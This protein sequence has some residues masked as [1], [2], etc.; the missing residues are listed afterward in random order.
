M[1]RKEPTAEAELAEDATPP[2]AMPKEEMQARGF[3]AARQARSEALTEDYVELI[4]D[5]MATGGE[6]RTGRY[7]PAP[8]DVPCDRRQGD[9]PSQT[10]RIGEQ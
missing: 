7:C 3:R 4:A 9:S 6:A 1:T 2:A 8:G 5:L 10:R